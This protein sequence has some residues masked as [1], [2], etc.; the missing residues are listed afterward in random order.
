MFHIWKLSKKKKCFVV[1]CHSV[2]DGSKNYYN[3]WVQYSA[4]KRNKT[5][6]LLG[7]IF[8]YMPPCC[9]CRPKTPS[10][11]FSP[12]AAYSSLCLLPPTKEDSELHTCTRSMGPAA[13]RG[14][15]AFFHLTLF[16]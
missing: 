1:L 6:F 3:S 11:P 5:H 12:T 7:G 15:Q 16:A 13:D 14:D 9:I 2:S 4:G 8:I 10:K